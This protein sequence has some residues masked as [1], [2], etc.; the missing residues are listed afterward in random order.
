MFFFTI[1]GKIYYIIRGVYMRI[2][3]VNET[4]DRLKNILTYKET[5]YQKRLDTFD[6]KRELENVSILMI[7]FVV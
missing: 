2:K 5:N 6:K 7:L 3:R 1:N 4:L